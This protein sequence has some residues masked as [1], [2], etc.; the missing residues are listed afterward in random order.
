MTKKLDP[1]TLGVILLNDFMDE[2][3]Q[4]EKF[5]GPDTFTVFH[6]NGLSRSSSVRKVV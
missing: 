6:Y 2:F 4:N 5:G 3:Y 1:E